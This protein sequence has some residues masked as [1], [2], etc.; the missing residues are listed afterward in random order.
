MLRWAAE[1]AGGD[2]LTVV[3]ETCAPDAERLYARFELRET[4]A[5]AVMRHPLTD[6]PEVPL[7]E[8]VT[9]VPVTH[10]SSRDLFAAYTGSF[11]DRP[12]FLDLAHDEWLE[13]L[14]DDDEWRRDLSLVALAHGGD[15]PAGFVNVTGTW[16][17]QVGV[18]PAWRGRRLGA[19]L[20]ARV[21]QGLAAENAPECWL[22]VNTNNPARVL[23]ASLGFEDYGKRARFTSA[24]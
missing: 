1:R 23:Y 24:G 20:V 5:E 7:P 22:C 11:A 10:A 21:L 3:T 12:G 16:V 13:E 17:D 15:E 14:E 18:V 6:A 4:F 9:V 19:H 8:G 2:P